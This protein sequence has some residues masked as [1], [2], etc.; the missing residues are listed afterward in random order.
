VKTDGHWSII[1]A[2][3]G[4]GCALDGLHDLDCKSYKRS[5]AVKIW[6]NV[7]VESCLP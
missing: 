2:K 6:W 1:Y 3:Y 5:D 7:I 4:V